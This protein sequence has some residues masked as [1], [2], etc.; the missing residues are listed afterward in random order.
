MTS[1]SAIEPS[2]ASPRDQSPQPLRRETSTVGSP[3]DFCADLWGPLVG[4]LTLKVGDRGT[5]EELAQEALARAWERWPE[6]SAME[7]PDRWVFRVAL[8]LAGSWIRRR[9]A[10]RRARQ[11]L[12]QR[13]SVGGADGNDAESLDLRDAIRALPNREREV[14]ILRYYGELSVRDVAELLNISEGSVKSAAFDARARLRGT[15]DLPE[16]TGDR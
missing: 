6:V 9:G 14:I 3:D 1:R 15:L 7:A 4:T 8:N 10:E 5:A 13:S 12:I 2:H 16:Q 11:R